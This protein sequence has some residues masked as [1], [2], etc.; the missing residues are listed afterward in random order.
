MH[1]GRRESETARRHCGCEPTRQRE[2][3]PVWRLVNEIGVSDM[4]VPWEQWATV[5]GNI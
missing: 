5:S 3:V 4:V 2:I 1:S